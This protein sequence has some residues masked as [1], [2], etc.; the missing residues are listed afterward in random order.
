LV[1]PQNWTP[2]PYL[3]PDWEEPIGLGY[4]YRVAEACGAKVKMFIP[5]IGK[6]FRT[7]TPLG[8][9]F[10]D[11]TPLSENILDFV[12]RIIDWK[13]D[14]VGFQI[15]TMQASKS[16]GLAKW[17][18]GKLPEALI[19]AGG[20][21]P[22][23]DPEFIKDTAIDVS[24]IGEGEKAFGSIVQSLRDDHGWS[25]VP[26][27]VYFRDGEVVKNPP[28]E[29]IT[30][31]STRHWNWPK[32]RYF[33]PYRFKLGDPCS[34][35]YPAPSLATSASM[36]CSRGC[37]NACKFCSSPAMWG[38]QVICRPYE[39]IIDEI[40]CLQREERVD[41]IFF[42]DLSFAINRDWVR[43]F[44]Q[45]LIEEDVRVNWWCQTTI[46]SVDEKLLRLM[47]QAGCATI[48]WGIES[49]SDEGLS[50]MSKDQTVSEIA[51]TLETSASLGF[52]NWGYYII[53]FPW[54]T[55]E[56]ILEGGNQFATLPIHRPRVSIATPLPG[57]AWYEELPKDK[58][59]RD[60]SRYD[61]GHLVYRHPSIEPD[62]MERLQR[63]VWNRVHLHPD[64]QKR[65]EG[66]L[67]LEPR[68][69]RSFEEY[70]AYAN[71]FLKNA[72]DWGEE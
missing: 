5:Q 65:A 23:A 47:K 43:D 36:I 19:V 4:L 6:V 38:Q 45:T 24:V 9:V 10:V 16:I 59:S 3:D 42:E 15:Y 33:H 22:T 58:L 37:P 11:S 34:L 13:P 57:S 39:D 17:I 40:K 18:S 12:H 50:R 72:R 25:D 64:Y 63:T 8:E 14:V 71:R 1:Y 56:S 49:L 51:E 48:A 66:L 20:P 7:E 53:G 28:A 21:H 60:L 62:R 27:I 70:Q 35:Y 55:E 32:R 44:C 26:G 46:R 69:Q 52:I 30:D 67:A 61:T 54:E 68:Y 2:S 29:R 31:L 41:L